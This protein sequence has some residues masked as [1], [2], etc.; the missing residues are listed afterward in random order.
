MISDIE[1]PFD[2][3]IAFLRERDTIYHKK[4][5]GKPWPWTED[6]ILQSYR[7]TEVY[8]ERDRTSI[9]YQRTIRNFYTQDNALVFPATVLY[10]WFNRIETCE[11]LFCQPDFNNYSVFEHYVNSGG[12]IDILLRCI[13]KIPSPHITGAFI[14]TGKPGYEKA[15]GIIQYFNDWFKK[16]WRT[17]WT[18]WMDS[19]PTLQDMYEWIQ[20]D[21]AG[22]GTFM[23]AQLVADLKYLRFMLH[24]LD[25]WT[26][27]MPG[28]GS[29]RGLNMV[30]GQRPDQPWNDKVWQEKIQELNRCENIA[31]REFGLG[32]FHC[33][34]TQNHCCEFS[35]FEKVRTGTGRP[36]Q[37]FRHV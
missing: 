30:L 1:D 15:Y 29:K 7:F 20:E 13:D 21:A 12:D 17:K 34:D 31:L 2:R 6:R 26:W 32:P 10:R 33:Q 11:H 35:K 4:T 18:A 27:A 24:V 25:W 9:H 19:P 37:V 16:P 22:L 8:R 3:Y 5:A 28:P 14:I 36:R 23:T